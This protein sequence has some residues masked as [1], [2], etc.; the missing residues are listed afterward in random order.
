MVFKIE[1]HILDQ[2]QYINLQEGENPTGT[3]PILLRKMF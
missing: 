3:F 1:K 2:R